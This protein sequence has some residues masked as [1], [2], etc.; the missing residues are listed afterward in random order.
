MTAH[1][2]EVSPRDDL[3]RELVEKC[4][5]VINCEYITIGDNFFL[6]GGD[7]LGLIKI[8]AY[9]REIYAIDLSI[10]DM[11]NNPTLEN[12]HDMILKKIIEEDLTETE[13]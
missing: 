5:E 10:A 4:K 12:W 11:F 13:K 3:D 6:V 2:D 7:S 9:V 1:K 8:V